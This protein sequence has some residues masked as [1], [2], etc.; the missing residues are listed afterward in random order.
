MNTQTAVGPATKPQPKASAL[1]IM[2]ARLN[3]DPLK[4]IDTLKATVFKGATN[5]ELLALVVVANEYQLNPLLKELY[6]FPAKGG[7]IVPM[8]PIDGW[9]K[10]VNRQP[11]YDGVDFAATHDAD[12]RPVTCTCTLYIKG[13]SHPIVVTEYYSECYRKT[14]PWNNM[15]NRMLRHKAFIQAARLAFGF[16]GIHDDDEARDQALNVDLPPTKTL[17]GVTVDTVPGVNSWNCPA[18][19]QANAEYATVCGRCEMEKGA[20]GPTA[21]PQ[22]TKSDKPQSMTPQVELANLIIEAGHN[23]D[24]FAKWGRE[25][26]PNMPW[27]TITSFDEVPTPDAKRFQRAHVG[28]LKALATAK[29]TL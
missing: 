6:A 9:T 27:D 5:D 25:M 3:V 24:D 18:C 19:G 10:I 4:L 11:D 15:P 23:F 8:V 22:P 26:F 2:G 28:L 13:R 7:G 20:Q 17:T 29:G 1:G 21:P 16:S 14:D 12:G